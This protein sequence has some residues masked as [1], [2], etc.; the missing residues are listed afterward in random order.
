MTSFADRRSVAWPYDGSGLLADLRQQQLEGPDLT[1]RA[2]QNAAQLG[3][4]FKIIDGDVL[5][6][7][8]KHQYARGRTR[9][10]A[11]SGSG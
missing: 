2:F 6:L 8:S 1:L 7:A 3:V 5:D 10:R 11:I 9:T 4:P